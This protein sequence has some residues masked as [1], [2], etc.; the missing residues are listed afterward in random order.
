M[1]GIIAILGEDVIQ[2][3]SLKNLE[4]FIESRGP[5]YSSPFE[6]YPTK[7]GLK[8]KAKASLLHL[9]GIKAEKQP[10]TNE[11]G[12]ILLFNGQIYEYSKQELDKDLSDT[13]FLA[14]KLAKC[15]DRD[16]IAET[17]SLIDGPFAFIYWNNE[18]NCL[19]YG[20]DLLG[21]KSLCTLSSEGS[22]PA[23][24]SSVIGKDIAVRGG[25]EPVWSEVDCRGFHCIDMSETTTCKFTIYEW[26]LDDI[27]PPTPKD[28]ALKLDPR[29]DRRWLSRIPLDRLNCDERQPNRFTDQERAA[30]MEELK[31]R[32]RQAIDRRVKYNMDKCLI[33]RKQSADKTSC[34]HSKIAVAFSGGLD[35]TL[36]ALIL[37]D[38]VDK[39]ETIDLSSVA[40]KD[41]S[42]DREHVI[43]AFKE[44]RKLCP[45]RN[46]RLILRDIAIDEL[47]SDRIDTVHHL[48]LPCDTVVDDSLGCGC[49][50][51]SRANGRML[52]SSLC[53]EEFDEYFDIFTQFESRPGIKIANCDK[54][55]ADYT[56]PATMF[57]AGMGIDEQLGGY[58][59]HRAAWLKSGSRGACE[60]IAF[61][62]RRIPSRNLGRDD[63][64][65]SH[66][67][68]DVKLPYLD[69]DLVSYLNSL[70]VGLKFDLD[71]PQHLGPK[72]ILRDL[73]RDLGLH[74]TS[75]QVKRAMQFGIRIANLENSKEKGGDVCTRLIMSSPTTGDT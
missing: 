5:D 8:L 11:R 31:F 26:K 56:S 48:I 59:S 58:S 24:I 9:R 37:D 46:W 69:Y 13:R 65:F 25:S 7:C 22:C 73:A 68:R 63:R 43:L 10:V 60:E 29:I 12:D 18:F 61:Q 28:M 33:C 27:Y 49:W 1:C 16:E 30:S 64:T 41:G 74:K 36:I 72:Q 2:N 23:V 45:G 35:S 70:P 75:Q 66:H 17:F 67:G 32:L 54:I 53:D 40:F 47:K 19:F 39:N 62:M 20:R 50:Y 3:Q 21:R 42:P 4:I 57:F 44:L 14:D 15:R 6:E 34:K 51:I 52:E 38:V 55:N 71:K